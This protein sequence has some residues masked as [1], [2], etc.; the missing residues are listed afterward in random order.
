MNGDQSNTN[1]NSDTQQYQ[2]QHEQC[3]IHLSNK[4]SELE[5]SIN[6][7]ITPV[8]V[9]RASQ[10]L[11]EDL[12]DTHLD[13]TNRSHSQKPASKESQHNHVHNLTTIRSDVDACTKKISADVTKLALL[14]SK[15]NASSSSVISVFQSIESSACSLVHLCKVVSPTF[16]GRAWRSEVVGCVSGL[17]R[18]VK[19]FLDTLERL[20]SQREEEEE[21]N[22]HVEI[23]EETRQG[24]LNST[25]VVWEKCTALDKLSVDNRE[26]VMRK[27]K[28]IEGLIEDCFHEVEDAEAEEVVSDEVQQ[29]LLMR[30]G[31]EKEEEGREEEGGELMNNNRNNNTDGGSRGGLEGLLQG[32]L[33]PTLEEPMVGWTETDKKAVPY[34]KS[35]VLAMRKTI[36]KSHSSVLKNMTLQQQEGDN[37]IT[38]NSNKYNLQSAALVGFC[39]DLLKAAR[40]ISECCDDL[41]C[42][43]YPPQSRIAVLGCAR[44]LAQHGQCL[45]TVLRTHCTQESGD[46]RW[47]E[48]FS[49]GVE[50]NIQRLASL[51]PQR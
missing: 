15:G 28:D 34:V 20:N 40:P 42:S 37:C 26:S 3:F 21:E 46:L 13:D 29:A 39:D 49:K 16:H 45:L 7:L 38:N 1:N 25:G 48:L 9:R 10:T 44:Q 12:A 33:D 50:H 47:V 32:Y 11:C 51:V 17:F 41:A 5:A 23:S 2:K 19:S 36:H 31:N 30:W 27:L 14:F 24:F 4:L 43:L 35:L 6:P 18:G 22:T 8:F